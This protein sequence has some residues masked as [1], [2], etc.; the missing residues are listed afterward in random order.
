MNSSSVHF[1]L[2]FLIIPSGIV[3]FHVPSSFTESAQIL[4]LISVD[5]QSA[6]FISFFEKLLDVVFPGVPAGALPT[7][8]LWKAASL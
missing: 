8:M 1:H 5:F 3:T 6:L 2:L 4:T 7:I